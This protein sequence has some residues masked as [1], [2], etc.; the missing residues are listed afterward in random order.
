[1]V[2]SLGQ[3]AANTMVNGLRVKRMER[4]FTPTQRVRLSEVNGK[5]ERGL[6]GFQNDEL[7]LFQ[8]AIIP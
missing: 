8:T 2:Y 4:H 1:M 3:M 5:K 7:F 6:D